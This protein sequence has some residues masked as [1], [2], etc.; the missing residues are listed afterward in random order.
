MVVLQV[1]EVA[2]V[3]RLKNNS[4]TSFVSVIIPVY[5]DAEALAEVLADLI[6][7]E[8]VIK[9]VL[10]VDGSDD[11]DVPD[12]LSEYSNARLIKTVPQRAG[13]MNLGAEQAKGDVLWFLHADTQLVGN[14]SE[15]LAAF[16]Q[17]DNHLWGR[18][19]VSLD[20]NHLMLK[21]VASMMNHRSKVSSICTGDQG[22][23][24]RKKTF[25]QVG[26]YPSQA[27][28]EDVELSKKLKR[29]SRMY[30]PQ[31]RLIT[32]S[33]KWLENGI[34]KTIVTMWYLRFIYWLGASPDTIHRIYYGR[35]K[36]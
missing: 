7:V 9:E 35:S 36:N 21:V 28:M 6:S 5:Q 26:G 2:A 17:S 27:L 32:S 12:V 34:L 4:L 30:I 20:S 11:P 1:K 13:Q 18:F 24:V 10:V 25:E 8:Q 23:F 14:I 15:D 31:G 22:I 29:L 3:V 19:N 16:Y 33:R